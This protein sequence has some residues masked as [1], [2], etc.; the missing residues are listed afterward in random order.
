MLASLFSALYGNNRKSI[1]LLVSSGCNLFLA[2]S[3]Y[4][5]GY[6]SYLVERS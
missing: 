1:N 2:N 3:V 6:D 4:C 5:V